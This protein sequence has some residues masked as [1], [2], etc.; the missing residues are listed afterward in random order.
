MSESISLRTGA[1]I[2]LWMEKTGFDVV[3]AD[4]DGPRFFQPRFMPGAGLQSLFLVEQTFSS[5]EGIP[6]VTVKRAFRATSAEDA[7]LQ[8]L[9]EPK[10][11]SSGSGEALVAFSLP[12]KPGMADREAI[13]VAKQ[14][15]K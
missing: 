13:T 1:E 7:L 8:Y 3:A 6:L 15:G 5:E 2:R 4:S 9:R 12:S 10:D 14:Q 11:R